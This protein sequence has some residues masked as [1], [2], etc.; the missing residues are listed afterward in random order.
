[1]PLTLVTPPAAE[2]VTLAEAKA[3]LRVEVTDDDAI[4]TALIAA[5]RALAEQETGRSLITQ[6]WRRTHD[7]F[8]DSVRLDRGPVQS[9]TSV[10]YLESVAGEQ[11]TLS[12]ASYIVDSASAPG[13]VQPAYG[14]DWPDVWPE[15]NAVEVTYVTG[16]GADGTAIPEPIKLWVKLM[17]GHYYANREASF[18]PAARVVMTPL[19]F[20]DGLLDPFRVV[21]A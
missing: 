1:M 12:P 7:Q 4:I 11:T 5:A 15:I 2:P 13:W 6:T 8:P 20:I 19:A 9:V 21:W 10:K 18:V 16:Y 3:H 14:F 17:V